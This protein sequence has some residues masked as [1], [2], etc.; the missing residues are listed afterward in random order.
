MIENLLEVMLLHD[1]ARV[2]VAVQ[3]E[4]RAWA[5]LGR[6]K[7][8]MAPMLVMVTMEEWMELCTRTGPLTPMTTR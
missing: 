6:V 5:V 3:D 8:L 2:R 7:S 4:E 1:T